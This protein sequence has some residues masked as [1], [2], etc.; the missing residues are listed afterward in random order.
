MAS[1]QQEESL[2]SYQFGE[3]SANASDQPQRGRRM[4]SH[5]VPL[6]SH[7]PKG[8][9]P[10]AGSAGAR[11]RN[12]KTPPVPPRRPS[13]DGRVTPPPATQAV[14]SSSSSQLSQP[15]ASQTPP[16][17]PPSSR[18]PDRRPNAN[19]APPPVSPVQ[20]QHASSSSSAPSS[21]QS[22]PQS[23][24]EGSSGSRA[25]TRPPPQPAATASSGASGSTPLGASA[26]QNVQ[27]TPS[28]GSRRQPELAGGDFISPMDDPVVAM[29][30]EIMLL[31]KTVE[32]RRHDIEEMRQDNAVLALEVD[33]LEKYP[34]PADSQP[35]DRDIEEYEALLREV[36]RVVADNKRLETRL[37]RLKG[38]REQD[39]HYKRLLDELAFVSD[40]VELAAEP[41]PPVEDRMKRLKRSLD[42]VIHRSELAEERLDMAIDVNA[43][44]AITAVEVHRACLEAIR[45]NQGIPTETPRPHHASGQQNAHFV[46][47]T[48]TAAIGAS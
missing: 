3:Q 47:L 34:S 13:K 42:R 2:S 5:G 23:G 35:D 37:T 6:P 17:P 10:P 38:L 22:R 19:A 18:A 1:V 46:S 20:P 43:R 15:P 9:P 7:I 31:R 27:P 28:S 32:R 33:K 8:P 25:S 39:G 14:D 16:T 21:V 12:T 41:Q 48:P 36:D 40:L 30:S 44:Q 11:E 26:S 24:Q 29:Q 4:S 45:D